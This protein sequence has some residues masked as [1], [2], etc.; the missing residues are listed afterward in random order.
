METYDNIILKR[1]GYILFLIVLAL[2]IFNVGGGNAESANVENASRKTVTFGAYDQDN[3]PDNGQEPVEWIVLEEKD[4]KCLLL[5]KCGLDAVSYQ[6]NEGDTDWEKST[7]RAWLNKDFL[8]KS[9]TADE[10]SAIQTTT[11]VNGAGQGASYSCNAGTDTEDKIFLLSYREAFSVYFPQPEDRLCEPTQTAQAHG[12]LYS[13][14]GDQNDIPSCVWWLRSPADRLANAMQ[15][16][17]D[18]TEIFS[19]V[20]FSNAA[21]RPALWVNAEAVGHK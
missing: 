11:V 5:S 1:I 19:D 16:Y 2:H 7:L 13:L 18:S 15:V 20:H 14:T 12:V 21:V 6:D 3:N 10:Q 17:C 4:G 9:F 8:E